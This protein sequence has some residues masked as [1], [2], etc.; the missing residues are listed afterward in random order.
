MGKKKDNE[1]KPLWGKGGKYKPEMQGTQGP[2][3]G[4]TKNRPLLINDLI[5]SIKSERRGF[6]NTVIISKKQGKRLADL[7]ARARAEGVEVQELG[8]KKYKSREFDLMSRGT[9]SVRGGFA[10][11]ERGAAAQALFESYGGKVKQPVA[12][13]ETTPAKAG[14]IVAQAKSAEIPGVRQSTPQYFGFYT[15]SKSGPRRRRFRRG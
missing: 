3:Y 14:K 9:T 6:D 4:G 12:A 8:K 13:T 7:V 1:K 2:I 11:N 5:S 15:G 10:N